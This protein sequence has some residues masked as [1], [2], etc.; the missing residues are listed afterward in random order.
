MCAGK[1]EDGLIRVCQQHLLI[2][3][4]GPRVEPDDGALP[5]FDLFDRPASIRQKRDPDSIADRGDIT[6]RLA[7]FQFAAQL[8]N[9]GTQP[10]FHGKKTGLGFND[11][12]WLEILSHKTL[13]LSTQRITEF[14]LSKLSVANSY[15]SGV[16]VGTKPKGVGV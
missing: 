15:R 1:D 10:G 4:L 8:T 5:S 3:T 9:D 2:I 12:A 7:L 6:R 16:W 14:F 11:Q 13:P